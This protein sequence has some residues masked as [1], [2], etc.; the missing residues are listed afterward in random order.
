MQNWLLMNDIKNVNITNKSW[1]TVLEYIEERNDINLGYNGYQ[2]QY[3]CINSIIIKK[4]ELKKLPQ[5]MRN[6]VIQS[7]DNR[8]SAYDRT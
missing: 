4:K 5:L 7:A 3:D 2:R 1:I 6:T 8:P